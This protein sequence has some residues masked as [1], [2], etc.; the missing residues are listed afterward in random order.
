MED[1]ASSAAEAALKMEDDA[2]PATA[3]ALTSTLTVAGGSGASRLHKTAAREVC[4]NLAWFGLRFGAKA[5][6][7]AWKRKS[8]LGSTRNFTLRARR[9]SCVKG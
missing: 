8:I 4:D 5:E 1:D 6:L 7:P 2:S 9:N 3:A